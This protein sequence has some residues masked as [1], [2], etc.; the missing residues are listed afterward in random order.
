MTIN[1]ESTLIIY[2]MTDLKLA[3]NIR[4]RLQSN[5]SGWQLS[6][7]HLCAPH[8]SQGKEN[9]EEPQQKYWGK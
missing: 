3:S 6:V 7:C 9:H 1:A 8:R 4:G 5:H 2:T